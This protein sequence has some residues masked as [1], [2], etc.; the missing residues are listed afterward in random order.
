MLQIQS[1]FVVFPGVFG[2]KCIKNTRTPYESTGESESNR[3]SLQDQPRTFSSLYQF[4]CV[5]VVLS[6]FLIVRA[7]QALGLTFLQETR[8]ESVNT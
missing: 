8:K 3:D 5:T 6:L 1:S 4:V 2:K 7:P